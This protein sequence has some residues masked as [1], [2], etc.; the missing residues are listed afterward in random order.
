M[1]KRTESKR[2]PMTAREAMQ[3]IADGASALGWGIMF[4]NDPNE[5]AIVRYVILGYQE[6]LDRIDKLISAK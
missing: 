4:K 2:K 3:S 6:E 5:N 1:K